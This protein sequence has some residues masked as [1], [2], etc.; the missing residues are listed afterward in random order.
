MERLLISNANQ[1]DLWM[2]LVG[3]VTT[4][5]KEL[6]D[7]NNWVAILEANA[8]EIAKLTASQDGSD[9]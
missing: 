1:N 5:L 6:G 8:V 9:S 2:S 3:R 7:V 4:E